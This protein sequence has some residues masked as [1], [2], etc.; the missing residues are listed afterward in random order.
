MA[1]GT[2]LGHN[3]LRAHRRRTFQSNPLLSERSLRRI[4]FL[5]PAIAL[6]STACVTVQ[7]LA[8][9]DLRASDHIAISS[10][11]PLLLRGSGFAP[12]APQLDCR[13]RLLD[14]RVSARSGDSLW[15]DQVRPRLIAE[16]SPPGCADVSSGVMVLEDASGLRVSRREA[17]SATTLLVVAAA[18]ALWLV[19][20]L[21]GASGEI[22]RIPGSVP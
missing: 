22:R 14:A 7:S 4:Q 6:F 3:S 5:T 10:E 1:A 13:M 21:H 2:A 20:A 12:S 19:V 15:V 11:R 8:P 18:V 9:R 16:G 17:D